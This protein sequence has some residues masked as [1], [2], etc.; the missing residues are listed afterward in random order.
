MKRKIF[1]VGFFLLFSLLVKAQIYNPIKWKTSVEKISDTEYE[2]QAKAI[3]EPG[4]HLYS[5]QVAD[6]GPIAT[7]FDFVKNADYQ[8]VGSIKE[9]K[10]KTINDPVF[11]M[12]I[13]FFEK[14]TTF[15]QR[16]KILSSKAFKINAE[17]EFMVC[18][19]ENCLPPSSEEIEFEVS[20]K[21]VM[22]KTAISEKNSQ[23]S[24]AV[25]SSLSKVATAITE[26]T[27]TIETKEPVSA[28]EPIKIKAPK[29]NRKPLE[30]NKSK[31]F[32]GIFIIAFLSGFAALLTP[33]VF[34]MIP[35]TVSFF[36]K[37]SKTK[38]AGIR[39]ALIYGFSIII[40][41]V[42]L[43]SIVTAIFGADSLN[44]LST[45]VW[46]NLI[47]FVL[48]LV[49]ACSFL[50]AFEI[51]LPNSLANKVDS[52]ADKGGLIGIFFMALALAIVSFSCTGPIVGTL[53]VEAASKGG[54]APIVGMLGFSIAIALPFSLF[55]AFPGWLNALPKSG[56]WLNTVKV[57]LGFLELALAF[58]F[59]SNADLVL[60]LHWL[61]REVFLVIW[62]AIFGVLALYLFGK[63]TLPHDS[64]LNHISVGRVAVGL[65][66]LSFTL[67][68]IPGLFGAPLKLISGFPPPM[69]YSESPDGFGGS[70]SLGETKS[71]LPEGAEYGPQNIITFHDYDKG[72]EFAKKAGKP[73]LLDFTGYACV[74]CRKMEELVWSDARVLNV[75]NNDVVLISLYVDDK[76]ELG[77]KEQYISETT[78]KKIKTIGN[79]WSDLQIKTYKA[80]AQPF[81]VIIDHNSSNLTE[82]SAYNPDIEAYYNWLNKGI[83]NFKNETI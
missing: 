64:P 29:E 42:L 48:L 74:N 47:F 68:L 67:Y 66:V 13:K 18:N 23:I 78:G 25:A 33:C 27:E 57:V 41:Y 9:E 61:Q 45:N 15:R 44:A 30:N 81:Y 46:F 11:K 40:I 76:Q 36:T 72:M 12:Q 4:W 56:G 70:K 65:V 58:K 63:I 38:A 7:H 71:A 28:E 60:Q 14:E 21:V 51:M 10:G 34:P 5:Q 17:V 50:G 75:L 62:I 82:P 8:L 77:E 55:A 80:N 22:S 83:K 69:Q 19:N 16:I 2:L 54:I 79:K 31:S 43:G 73:V 6:G 3:I 49:F 32:L 53:L 37:Q 24:P 52:Q 59:L 39:N 1:L 26:P 35:M 20:P